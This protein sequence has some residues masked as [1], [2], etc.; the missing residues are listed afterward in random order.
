MRKS[1]KTAARCLKGATLLANLLIG[2]RGQMR[3]RQ[4]DAAK[5]CTECQP[6]LPFCHSDPTDPNPGVCSDNPGTERTEQ[7]REFK[8]NLDLSTVLKFQL[9]QP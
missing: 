5:Y 3:R 9:I 4:Q 8:E 7:Y 2:L 1:W 6:D